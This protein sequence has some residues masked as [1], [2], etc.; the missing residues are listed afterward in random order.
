MKLTIKQ[1][2]VRAGVSTK[3][4]YQWCDE[5]R[6]AHF[7]LGGSGKRGRIIIED[8][9]LDTFLKGCRVEAGSDEDEGPLLHID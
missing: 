2:A 7:R 3:L 1:A 9:D 4:V 6:L 8:G 5:R